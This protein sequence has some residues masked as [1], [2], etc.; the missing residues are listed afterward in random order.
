M[1][2][3]F[4]NDL[5][6]DLNLEAVD[7]DTLPIATTVDEAALTKMEIEQ[8]EQVASN[9]NF[10]GSLDRGVQEEWIGGT[11][12]N[13]WDRITS[14]SGKPISK[15]TPELVNQLTFGI[16]DRVA[17]REVLED[18]TTNGL[19]S[20][21]LM[22]QSYL[23]TQKNLEYIE[24]DGMSGTTARVIAMLTDPVEWGAIWAA[25][26]GATAIGS[27]IAGGSVF[28]LGATKKL[29]TAYKAA[30]AASIAAT[31]AAVFEGIRAKYRY[32]IDGGDVMVAM[33]LSA[34]LGGSFDAVSTTLIRN[35]QR[36]LIA[37]KIAR[38]EELSD[39]E[40]RWYEENSSDAIT[41]RII[42]REAQDGD[43]FAETVVTKGKDADALTTKDVAA[44]PDIDSVNLLWFT[45]KLRRLVSTGYKLGT[46]NL[47]WAR[48]A[49]YVLG[50]N[51]T[52]YRG[53]KLA[54]NNSASEIAEQLQFMYRD[55]LAR[56][57]PVEQTKW[58]KSTGGSFLDF[59]R[60]VSRYVRGIE[61][62][63]PEEV[64]R[65]GERIKEVQN[66]LAE[67]A[68]EAGV[69]GFT[70]DM[71]TNTNYMSRIFS[72]ERIR[73]I[74]ARLGGGEE[75]DLQI[76]ML[77]E[78]AIRKGQPNIEENVKNLLNKKLKKKIGQK[79]IDAYIT[80]ISKA[81]TRSITDPKFARTGAGGANE[82]NLEDLSAILKDEGFTKAEID[83]I[84]ELMTRTNIPKSHK[85]ARPR[86]LLDE[87]ATVALRNADG[88]VE[89][90]RFA[91]LLE[92]DAEQ[93]VNGYVFQLS[94][95]IGLAR[96]GINTNKK[97]SGID[98]IIGQIQ[99]EGAEAN[100]STD[101]IKEMTDAV[102]F[103]YDGITGRL[104]QREEVSNKA[105]ENFIALR[106]FSFAVNMGMSGM[107]SL[108]EISNALFE[109]SF[110]TLLKSVPAYAKLLSRFQDGTADESLIQELIDI[111][112]MGQEVALGKWN[113]VTRM[114]TEDV[115]AQVISP[116][117]AW[118]DK[119][120][121]STKALDG[122][123][124]LSLRA[125]KGVAYWSGLT[126]VTQTLRRMT[127]LNFTNEWALKAAKGKLPFSKV[128]LNQLGLDDEM[129]EKIRLTMA[130]NIVEKNANGTV[131]KLNIDQWDEDVREAFRA[132][133]FKEARQ[134]VQETNIASMNKTLRGE[135]GKTFGQFLS[136]TMASLEQQTSR[137][138]TRAK[139][140]DIAVAKVMVSA[141]MMGGLMYTARVYMNAAGRSDREEY[142]KER[143]K[144][145]K[146]MLGALGQVGASSL[147]SYVLQVA[148]G[149]MQG[150]G[151]AITPP[152]VGIG[153][154]LAST[155]KNLFDKAMGDDMTEAEWRK[156]LRLVPFQSLYGARQ[157]LNAVAASFAD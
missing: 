49:S 133:G 123:G 58:Q 38:G 88:S 3:K 29:G 47:G 75:A 57:L 66:E 115:G 60:L 39:V 143:M 13:N 124:D 145:D 118:G 42:A 93:L 7:M 80:R 65:A 78:T 121:W 15:F 94:G 107:S 126:G 86:M 21:L 139:G 77:V 85:R 136:F 62:D 41:A 12:V 17:V 25:S 120:G 35:G 48:Y 128:K 122:A 127:M 155:G 152:A 135:Y 67:L 116:E 8:N 56:I 153:L 16:K 2:L 83:D 149:S 55:R 19:N 53:Q 114:D 14:A 141:A 105:R 72:E 117:R 64:I 111:M 109:Y 151:Y 61:T 31:E 34:A 97:N 156:M 125:Q 59:N 113:N 92:E 82:M 140:K 50:M 68:S 102:E 95:A 154:N 22:K 130:S 28:M 91:D 81:Y 129:A 142:I 96:N 40:K 69:S 5:L 144:G 148:S 46:S 101:D 36:N 146:L 112:G 54:A 10:F 33:G 74:R 27:P 84:T 70:K 71:L 44:L 150:N 134:N 23:K 9:T 4:K 106:A 6:E 108:M 110:K 119:R 43:E 137:L 26:A 32:D 131:K 79:D 51:S 157:A 103:M 24:A 1:A 11:V 100:M 45:N 87:G 63:V 89:D 18:A 147:F 99:K 132:A 37:G 73:S 76:A 90:Y 98:Y 20:A 30:T 138:A 104:A 52:G